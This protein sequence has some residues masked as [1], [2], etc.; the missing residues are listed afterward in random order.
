MQGELFTI[1]LIIISIV[2]SMSVADA[3]LN[4]NM[5]KSAAEIIIV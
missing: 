3:Y 1:D 5:S 2:K 4:W